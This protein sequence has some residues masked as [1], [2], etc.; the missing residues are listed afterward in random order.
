MASK[1]FM[2]RVQRWQRRARI[3][4]RLLG[5][6]ALAGD[7]RNRAGTARRRLW[8]FLLPVGLALASTTAI[9]QPFYV[10]SGSMEPTIAIG[11]EIV[12]SKYSYGYGK[13]AFPYLDMN[14]VQGRLF[15]ATPQ[16]GDIAVFRPPSEPHINLVKRVI[17][18]PGDRIQMRNGRLSINGHE[19]VLSRAGTGMVEGPDG[20]YTEV[21]RYI[22]TMPDGRKHPIFKWQWDGPLDNTVAFVVPAGHLFMMGDDRDNSFDSRV[23]SE[24]GGIGFIP[25]D[26]LIGRARFVLGS[27]DYLNASSI[28]GWPAEMRAA[29]FF[30]PLM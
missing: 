19:L 4:L 13:Y 11:D 2:A 5:R 7:W 26:A 27:I 20:V 3:G 16:R 1:D 9:A 21:P 24:R 18:L 12:V 23:P 30:K 25:L 17:G 29:R 15:A 8:E 10:P 14:F 22:E 6:K 28:L